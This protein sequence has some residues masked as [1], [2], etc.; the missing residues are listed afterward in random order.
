MTEAVQVGI[1]SHNVG[2]VKLPIHQKIGSINTYIQ[3]KVTFWLQNNLVLYACREQYSGNLSANVHRLVSHWRWFWGLAV[4]INLNHF[5]VCALMA[6]WTTSYQG[7]GLSHY[8]REKSYRITETRKGWELMQT[9]CAM[10]IQS[11]EFNYLCEGRSK[12]ATRNC[13]HCDSQ[14][15]SSSSIS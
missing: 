14:Y 2:N 15:V 11:S 3:Q 7:K 10:C 6:G 8:Q 4:D 13:E 1:E 12:A 9:A 5:E